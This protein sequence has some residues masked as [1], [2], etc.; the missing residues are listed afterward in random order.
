MFSKRRFFHRM[1]T[2]VDVKFTP[3]NTRKSLLHYVPVAE[4]MSCINSVS[5][6]AEGGQEDHLERGPTSRRKWRD[7]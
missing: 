5:R 2:H 4:T 6:I 1:F 3:E 7:R